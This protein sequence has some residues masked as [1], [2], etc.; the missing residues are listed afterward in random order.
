MRK[1]SVRL[2]FGPA[3]KRVDCDKTEERSVQIFIPYERSFSLVFREEE[4][5]VRSDHF[6]LKF[7]VNW[8]QLGDFQQIFARSASAVTPSEESSI[9]IIGSPY[10]LSSEP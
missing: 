10:A 8:P 6:Y 3:A 7:W 9:T 5:L 2:S 1:L 4:W